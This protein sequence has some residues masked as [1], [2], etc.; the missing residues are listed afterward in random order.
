MQV[1]YKD[2]SLVV[3]IVITGKWDELATKMR[4]AWKTFFDQ[5]SAILVTR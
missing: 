5:S 2:K 1:V 4:A 3:G